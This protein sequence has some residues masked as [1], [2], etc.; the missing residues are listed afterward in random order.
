MN[1]GIS[2]PNYTGTP[3]T[4]ICLHFKVWTYGTAPEALGYNYYQGK[5]SGE[6]EANKKGNPSAKQLCPLHHLYNGTDSSLE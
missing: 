3:E 6:D 4:V 1:V 5:Y 2:V